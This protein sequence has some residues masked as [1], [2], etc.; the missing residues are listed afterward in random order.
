M[1]FNTQ[2]LIREAEW[3]LPFRV[4]SSEV[5]PRRTAVRGCP[6]SMRIE[7]KRL[8]CC[9]V[10]SLEQRTFR[11]TK[12]LKTSVANNLMSANLHACNRSAE[13]EG[14]RLRSFTLGYCRV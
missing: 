7:S 5:V 1:E 3:P 2:R 11:K 10:V 9:V 12:K 6:A 14:R 8:R 4:G 13:S